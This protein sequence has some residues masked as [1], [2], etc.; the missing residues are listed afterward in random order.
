MG[1]NNGN[2]GRDSN[3]TLIRS[4][5]KGSRHLLRRDFLKIATGTAGIAVA[6]GLG[7]EVAQGASRKAK[8]DTPTITCVADTLRTIFIQICAGASGAPAGFS[9]QWVKHSDY[10]DLNCGATGQGLLWPDSEGVPNLCKAS[11]SGTPGCS[12]YNLAQNACVT[13]EI[14]NLNDAVCGVGLSNCGANELDC[15]TEYVFR[16]FAHATSKVDRSDYTANL[17]CSTEICLPACVRGQGYWKTHACNWPAPF[18]PGTPDPTDANVDGVP[19]NLQGQCAVL[20]NDPNTQ[21][22][23]DAVNMINIGGWA[24]NQ[25][26]LLCALARVGQ[27]NALVILAHQLIAAKLNILAGAVPP[28]NCD[29]AAADALIGQLNIL[30][31]SVATGGP[32]NTLGQAM[33]AAAGCL[34]LY[35]N[36]FGGVTSCP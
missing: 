36:G 23:C 15:G 28:P 31:D 27:G 8:Y 29:I 25:C 14:G 4:D 9:V 35:N 22:P 13:V 6:S 1:A 34:D 18:V 2:N 5:G 10:P 21:C 30:T 19:D 33:I 26:Q 12:I 32:G 17:C 20:G 24:Y 3:D 11:F 16:A 7:I